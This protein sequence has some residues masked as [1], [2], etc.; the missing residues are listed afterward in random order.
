MAPATALPAA[1]RPPP[2]VR[3]PTYGWTLTPFITLRAD[4]PWPPHGSRSTADCTTDYRFHHRPQTALSAEW[5]SRQ[6]RVESE[7]CQALRP[8]GGPD[9]PDLTV[10][11]TLEGAR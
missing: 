1:V 10:G 5:T 2:K 6:R 4:N 3:S 7:T 8:A 11:V 9:P